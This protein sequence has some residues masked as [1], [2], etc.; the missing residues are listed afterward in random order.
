SMAIDRSGHAWI[1]SLDGNVYKANIGTLDCQVAPGWKGNQHGFMIFG[2]GFSTNAANSKE[3]TLFV[4][5]ATFLWDAQTQSQLPYKGLATVALD[6]MMLAPVAA[7]DQMTDRRVELTGTGNGK[8]FGAFEGEPY[9]VAEIEKG[10]GKL[11][12]QAPQ[13]PISFAPGT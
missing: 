7:F 11:L 6:M 3:E 13:A 8:L 1:D 2:M 10:T 12:S 4:S 9:V 5:D